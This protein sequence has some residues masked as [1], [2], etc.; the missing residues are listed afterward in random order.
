MAYANLSQTGGCGR[1]LIAI[2]GVRVDRP[3][4]PDLSADSWELVFGAAEHLG[5]MEQPDHRTAE[6]APQPGAD[7]R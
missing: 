5:L 3:G 4:D 2:N 1:S 7:R 6:L